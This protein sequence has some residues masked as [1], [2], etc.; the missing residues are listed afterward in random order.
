MKLKESLNYFKISYRKIVLI[1]LTAFVLT[2]TLSYLALAFYLKDTYSAA[3]ISFTFSGTIILMITT[4][5]PRKYMEE[6]FTYTLNSIPATSALIINYSIS[7]S[8]FKSIKRVI[9]L[10]IPR[11]SKDFELI[12]NRI[13]KGEDPAAVLKS[14]A[15]KQ[16]SPVLKSGLMAFTATIEGEEV[17]IRYCLQSFNYFMKRLAKELEVKVTVYVTFLFFLPI[18]TLTALSLFNLPWQYFWL[19]PLIQLILAELFYEAFSLAEGI[20]K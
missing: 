5:Y 13:V 6:Q 12:L 19:I 4:Y 10:R 15:N 11:I 1:A 2:L 3:L 18:L 8:I 7:N 16:P 9:D 20:F 17:P 14:Y